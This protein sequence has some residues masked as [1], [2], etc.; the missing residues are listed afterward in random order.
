M[1]FTNISM[2]S[3]QRQWCFAGST[4]W[5]KPSLYSYLENHGLV[6]AKQREGGLTIDI[7]LRC[8]TLWS[9]PIV[10]E[11]ENEAKVFAEMVG[12]AVHPVNCSVEAGRI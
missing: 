3:T 11:W 5:T 9:V 10:E 2:R 4:R 1:E 7:G 8:G 12:R 6:R